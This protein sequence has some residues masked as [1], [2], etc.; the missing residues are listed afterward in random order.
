MT[1][2]QIFVQPHLNCC[3]QG[4]GV[5]PFNSTGSGSK[6]DVVPQNLVLAYNRV[7]SANVIN[8][9]KFG[10]NGSKTRVSGVVL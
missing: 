5:I 6:E 10:F 8:E 4:Y 1:C 9:A 3:D 7:H 2:L